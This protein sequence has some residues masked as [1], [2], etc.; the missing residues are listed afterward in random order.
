LVIAAELLLAAVENGD[1]ESGA[2][3][4]ELADIILSDPLVQMAT[5]VRS[6]LDE[7]SLFALSRA[8]ELAEV[9]LGHLWSDIHLQDG[10]SNHWK[11]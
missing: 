8:V 10:S 4:R 3:A 11:A 5:E 1:D 7:G 2:V 9:V 6:M